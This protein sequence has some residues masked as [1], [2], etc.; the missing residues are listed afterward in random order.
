M[1]ICSRAFPRINSSSRHSRPTRMRSSRA[2]P[3]P[4]RPSAS[5]VQRSPGER[6][7]RHVFKRIGGAWLPQRCG[8]PPFPRIFCANRPSQRLMLQPQAGQEIQKQLAIAAGESSAQIQQTMQSVSF[9]GDQGS[10]EAPGSN[11]CQRIVYM[12][13]T[14]GQLAQVSSRRDLRTCVADNCVDFPQATSF[15]GIQ[16]LQTNMPDMYHAHLC[17][18]DPRPETTKS[19]P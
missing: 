19:K 7:M 2:P 15:R 10:E 18:L 8:H 4:A 9:F 17:F 13:R 14:H 16:R 6:P 5:Y 1:L 12:S 11:M 3:A